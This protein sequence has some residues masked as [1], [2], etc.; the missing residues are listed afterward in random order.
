MDTL[1]EHLK[2]YIV[3]QDPQQYTPVEHSTWRYILSQ[4]TQY[5]SL[6][7]HPDYLKGLKAVGITTDRI[8]SIAQISEKLTPM[9]WRALPVSGFI[10]PAA[11]MELQS[12]GVLP[13]ATAMRSLEHLEYTPAPDIVHETA[14]H[15][16]LLAVPEYSN[17]LKAY[18][19]VSRRAV[20]SR[21]DLEIYKRIR[22]L[23]DLK[24][25]PSATATQLLEAQNLLSLAVKNEGKVSEAALLARMNWWTAEYGLI[26][27]LNNPK[28]YGAG[29]LSSVGESKSCL[30]SKV[31]KIPL[32][33][34]CLNYSYDITEPQPQL[35]VTP[36]FNHLVSVLNEFKSDMAFTSGGIKALLRSQESQAVNTH[37]LNSGLQISGELDSYLRDFEGRICFLKFKGPTQL[38]LEECQLPGHGTDYHSHGYS[39]PIGRLDN[40]E[41]DLKDWPISLWQERGYRLGETIKLEFESG[42]IVTG[43]LSN[44]VT[45]P[46]TQKVIIASLQ[47][48]LVTYKGQILF[49]PGWGTF[50]MGI[51]SA[52]N[53]VWGGPA[54]RQNYGLADDFESLQVKPKLLSQNDQLLHQHFDQLLNQNLN[55]TQLE[56]LAQEHLKLFGQD[57]LFEWELN[58]KLG[59]RN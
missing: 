17:Y 11:F 54:D 13:I 22:I 53:S 52:I 20:I 45:H 27:D 24:E 46:V 39:T 38:A 15:A 19:Q 26:G 2:K 40:F 47:Q 23:S 3:V 55:Q 5:L 18:A 6:H 32:T 21:Q 25:N 57:W 1:P 34:D 35:F 29:L 50:D 16:P 4:L 33:L 31:K 9:G 59:I 37:Q 42:L 14:G 10:P 30:S 58:I 51:G 49:E 56:N 44:L 36:D 28:L 8:P 41:E 12:L 7:A 48:A 43:I